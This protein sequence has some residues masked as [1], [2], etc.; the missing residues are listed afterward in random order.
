MLERRGQHAGAPGLHPQRF[1]HQ[2]P[3][4]WLAAGGADQDFMRLAGWRSQQML[5]RYAASAAG[6][7]AREAHRGLG[8]GHWVCSVRGLQR[9]FVQPGGI[10]VLEVVFRRLCCC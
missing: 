9:D 3:H 7:R 6:D 2:F 8:L 10:E 1:R 5:G 4:K